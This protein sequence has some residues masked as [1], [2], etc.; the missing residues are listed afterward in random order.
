MRRS[1][2]FMSR[3]K[4]RGGLGDARRTRQELHLSLQ[5]YKVEIFVLEVIMLSSRR[6]TS[7]L[8]H[9]STTTYIDRGGIQP[10]MGQSVSEDC[11]LT[12][13][14]QDCTLS[15]ASTNQENHFTQYYPLRT[16]G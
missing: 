10:R 15:V 2:A 3:P 9:H 12:V 6:D 13:S 8:D 11:M 16:K 14:L 4:L 5:N 7:R 1:R